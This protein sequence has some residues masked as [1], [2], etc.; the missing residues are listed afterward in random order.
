[1]LVILGLFPRSRA[2]GPQALYEQI[3]AQARRPDFYLEFGVADTVDGR[4]DMIVLHAWLVFRRLAM[5]GEKGRALA[6]E[7]FDFFFADMDRSLREMGVGDLSVPKKVRRMA[8]AF[9]GRAAAYDAHVHDR[10]ALGAALARNALRDES[11]AA[12]GEK[13]ASYVTKALADLC[14]QPA[15]TLFSGF[16][17]FPD[18][19]RAISDGGQS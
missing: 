6:Q 4:F 7:V 14:D 19:R 1:V 18:P 3:V 8:E 13:L 11:R 10:Q 9:Y 2:A 12:E 17:R 16:L 5:E 15:D